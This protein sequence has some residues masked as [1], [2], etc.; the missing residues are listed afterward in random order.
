MPQLQIKPI[1]APRGGLNFSLPA[2]LISDMEMSGGQNI[3]FEE[4]LV[5]KRYGYTQKGNNL[6]LSGVVNGS[7]QFYDFGG[8]SWLLKC[9]TTDV[10]KYNPTPA[11]WE[12]I[13]TSTQLHDCDAAWTAGSGDTI[14]ADT[15][16]KIEG[17]ASVK[18]TLTAERSDGDKLAYKNITSASII[19]H[20]SIGF[21]IKSSA[22]LAANALEVVVSESA[23]G[24]KSGT[25]CETLT[26]ALTADTWTFVRVAKTL[27]DYNAVVSVALYANATLASGLII[28]ID[29][30]RAYTP[31]TASYNTSSED[32]VSSDYI[33]KSTETDP[34]WIYTNGVDPLKYWTGSGQLANLISDYPSGVTTLLARHVVEFK[35]HLFL[36]D[37]TEDTDRYPQR[38][39]W[40]D[41]ADPED[42]L[43]GNASYV[44]L[45]GADWVQG[46]IKF[47]GDYLVVCK[48][49]S[50]W[51]GYATGDSDVFQFD[52]KITGTGCAAPKTIED[53]GD[54]VIFLGWDDVYAFDGTD[55]IS[56]TEDNVGVRLINSINPEQIGKCFGVIIEEQKE[57]WLFYPSV[58]SDYCDAAWCFNYNLNK[59]T[60]HTFSDYISMYGYYQIEASITIN[61]LVGT[62][63]Q[64]NWRFDDRTTLES[65]PTTLFGDTSGYIYEYDRTVSNDDG[66]AI[67]AYFDTK[68]FN[69]TQL[70]QR[71]WFP[72]LDVYYTG[73]SLEVW[74]STDKGVSWTL[75][76][77]LSANSSLADLIRVWSRLDITQVRMRFRNANAGEHFEFSRANMYW[78]PTGMRL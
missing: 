72:R 22:A 43:N 3:F 37:V 18:I 15:S 30:V 57:Y 47:K 67:D 39:R 69:P 54:E 11:M 27:T 70:M 24:A 49:R 10:Y 28:H 53:L 48:E 66:T 76:D 6:P 26:T 55:Y 23:D 36:W 35:D 21:W 4:G 77:T 2:D 56:L 7:D 42:F 44:D 60:R 40:S 71:F 46:A 33:R 73:D 20:N 19:A 64:Q 8:N 51:V 29:D 45:T 13:T 65:M 52:Q 12:Q 58:G 41:T 63:K 9:T 14:A 50:I 61:D 78:R 38:G 1:L 17:D 32:L 16:D 75:Q 59:W 5:K 31:L 25:Y 74:Y 34:W 62:I 68:D